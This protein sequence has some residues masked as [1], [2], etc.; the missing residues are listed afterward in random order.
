MRLDAQ[1][2]TTIR[3]L[4]L[5]PPALALA[6]VAAFAGAGLGLGIR[7]YH[8]IADGVDYTTISW[9]LIPP[10]WGL[11]ALFW[12]IVQRWS[13]AATIPMGLLAIFTGVYFSDV[14]GQY[15]AAVLF[16][17]ALTVVFLPDAAEDSD[18]ATTEAAPAPASEAR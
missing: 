5:G 11:L 8:A 9:A 14:Y 1:T 2:L 18:D 17:M 12:L 6:L 10:T 15:P 16:L 7:A 3:R 13:L 4:L